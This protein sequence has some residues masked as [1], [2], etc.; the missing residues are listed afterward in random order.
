MT[1]RHLVIFALCSIL[2]I[3]CQNIKSEKID[4]TESSFDVFS[5]TPTE[6]ISRVDRKSVV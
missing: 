6:E 4:D 1:T 5:P 2:M 3:S